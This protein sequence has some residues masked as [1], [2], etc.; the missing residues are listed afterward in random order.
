MCC[1][2]DIQSQFGDR[3]FSVAGPRLWNNLPT[4]RDPEERN[5][6]IIMRIAYAVPAWSSFVSKEQEGKIDALDVLFVLVL[7]SRFSPLG[8]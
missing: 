6:T 5:Y 2:A 1:P 4:D 7:V 3:S 8:K